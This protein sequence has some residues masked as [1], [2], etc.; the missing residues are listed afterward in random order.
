MEYRYARRVHV[1]PQSADQ[2]LAPKTQGF[3]YHLTQGIIH[4][5]RAILRV[6]ASIPPN[7]PSP[8]RRKIE[9]LGGLDRITK[10]QL[11]NNVITRIENLEH[12]TNLTW[13]DLSFNE[14]TEIRGLE[15]LTKLTDLSLTHNQISELENLDTLVNLNVLSIANNRIGRGK[16]GGPSPEVGAGDSRCESFAGN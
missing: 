4:H 12:L 8:C 16:P 7:T 11:D 6:S 2:T 13:L 5:L 10:L 1:V 3:I 14:I 15:T 9:N